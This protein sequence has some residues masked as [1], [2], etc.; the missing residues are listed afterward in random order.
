M[1][2]LKPFRKRYGIKLFIFQRVE[3]SDDDFKGEGQM[4][5]V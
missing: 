4:F 3:T 1:R 5:K 2:E